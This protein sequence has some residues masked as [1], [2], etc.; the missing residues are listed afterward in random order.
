VHYRSKHYYEQALWICFQLGAYNSDACIRS[1][2]SIARLLNKTQV[3]MSTQE[4]VRKCKQY[5]YYSIASECTSLANF[6]AKDSKKIN[7]CWTTLNN[8]SLGIT[9]F[10]TN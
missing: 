10:K 5:P 6:N 7:T 8:L 9:L 1:L 4:E 3:I 2:C